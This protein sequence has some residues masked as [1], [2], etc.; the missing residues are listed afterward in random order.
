[1][2]SLTGLSFMAQETDS[3][4][5]PPTRTQ[6][7]RIANEG[8]ATLYFPNVCKSKQVDNLGWL[9]KHWK[10]IEY[11]ELIDYGWG[12]DG[13]IVLMVKVWVSY[14]GN[15]CYYITKFASRSI[16]ERWIDRPVFNGVKVI[17]SKIKYTDDC[18]TLAQ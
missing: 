11:I 14:F 1:M 4:T 8:R 13:P 5:G 7:I 3:I 9:L 16:C 2:I 10:D 18:L 12:K 15:E 6:A 17:N